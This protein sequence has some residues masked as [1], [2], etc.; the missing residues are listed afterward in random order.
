VT[1]A[2][3]LAALIAERYAPTPR[4][5][6]GDPPHVLRQRRAWL[7]TMGATPASQAT[8]CRCTHLRATHRGGRACRNC[9]CTRFQEG[10]C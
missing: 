7:A 5:V 4:R 10:N 6:P 1:R 3:L 2:E 9:D 8:G